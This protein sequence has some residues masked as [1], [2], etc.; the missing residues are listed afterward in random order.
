MKKIKNILAVGIV[1]LLASC[2]ISGPLMVTDNEISD[3]RGEASY[4]VWLGFIRPMDA[5]VSIRTAAK[6]GKIRKVAT[7]DQRVESK[8]FRVTYTTVVTGS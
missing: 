5:D 2:S 4:T 6:N 8:L 3:K 7:V 1:T